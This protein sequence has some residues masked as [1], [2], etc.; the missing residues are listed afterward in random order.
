MR[1][2][3]AT[4]DPVR[5]SFLIA[6]LRD[7]GCAPVVLDAAISAVEG[8]IGIFPRRL[9]VAE[10]EAALAVRVLRDAGEDQDLC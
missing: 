4:T 9:A 6:L 1:V 2:L 10:D 8:G 7:A 3:L 5:L